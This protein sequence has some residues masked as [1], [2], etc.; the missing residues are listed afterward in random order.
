MNIIGWIINLVS[1]AIG[2]NIVGAA[3]KDKTL[4]MVGNTIAGLIGGAAGSYILQAVGILS[5]LGMSDMTLGSIAGHIGASA[6]GGGIL[7]AIVGIIKSAIN[8]HKA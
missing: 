5:S 4:G 2:G 6:A 3:W 8:K 1:G 7:T